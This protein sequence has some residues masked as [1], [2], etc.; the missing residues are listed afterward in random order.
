MM[1]DASNCPHDPPHVPSPPFFL[2]PPSLP[3]RLAF[4]STAHGLRVVCGRYV[5]SMQQ[6]MEMAQFTAKWSKTVPIQFSIVVAVGIE[7]APIAGQGFCKPSSAPLQ[8]KRTSTAVGFNFGEQKPLAF[9]PC[10][11]ARIHPAG[12]C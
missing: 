6:K 10:W 3:C 12:V 7:T 11:S 4:S 8:L 1:A 2:P 9:K 5:E